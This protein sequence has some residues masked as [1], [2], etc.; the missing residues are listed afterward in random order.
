MM[1]NFMIIGAGRSGT[2]SVYQYLRQHPQ[3][4]M[5]KI[6]ETNYFVFRASQMPGRP[7]APPWRWPVTSLDDYRAL[8]R[9]TNRHL[10]IGEASPFYLYAPRVPALIK[11]T[12]PE[13]RLI[14]ILRNP[15]DR[16]YSAYI[17]N[18]SEGF[19]TRPFEQAINEEIE[20][21]NAV[22]N[23]TTCYVRAG[24]YHQLLTA[25]LEVFDRSKL[26]I[27]FF[28]DLVDSP[29]ALMRIVFTGLG[30]DAEFVPDTSV[31]FNRG[32][33][34]PI[35]N[36]YAFRKVKGFSRRLGEH[37]PRRM[38]FFLVNFLQTLQGKQPKVTDL[39]ED[40]RILLTSLFVDDIKNLQVL[41]GRD[42]SEWLEV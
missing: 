14:A 34:L 42:L 29:T 40:T 36:N 28:Q 26:Q 33:M 25:Y 37:L 19:E 3:I 31:R 35:K 30:V 12:L 23:S 10:A 1:P 24:L 32:M 15:V 38:Y 8:F 20:G 27:Y 22:V 11:E 41:T 4:C 6:K 13:I 17:K 18:I 7:I 39:P 16:A 2:T 21:K 9:V 5:S